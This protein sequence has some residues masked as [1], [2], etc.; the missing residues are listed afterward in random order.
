MIE[1]S[2]DDE[3]GVATDKQLVAGST[4]GER[5]RVLLVSYTF[6]PVGGAGVQRP[7][8][9]AK[10]LPQF[11]WDVTVLTAANPSVP[12]FDDSLCADV[13]KETVI[14]KAKTLEPS[15]RVKS[16]VAQ[17]GEHRSRRSIAG[18]AKR[19]ALSA[20]KL[21]LQPDP[22]ILWKRDAVRVA[23]RYLRNH[24]HD[25][26][27]ATAP[28]Y[29]AFL[30]G[31]ALSRKTG[32]PLLVDY[33]DE[34]DISNANWENRGFSRLTLGWQKRVQHRVL[35]QASAIVATTES[36]TNKL[37][38]LARRVGAAP[39]S[40]CIY[41]GYDPSDFAGEVLKDQK[42]KGRFRLVYTGTLWNLT[43]IEPLVLA[44]EALNQQQPESAARLELVF[45]GRRTESQSVT[46]H[47]LEGTRCK[48]TLLDYVEHSQAVELMRS[49]NALCLVLSGAAEASRVVPAKLFE[50]AAAGKPILTI[51][52][53]GEVWELLDKHPQRWLIEPTQPAQIAAVLAEAIH[54]HEFTESPSQCQSGWSP[55]GFSRVEQSRKLASL[56]NEVA[57]R[58]VKGGAQ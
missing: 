49:A 14:L 8:K 30:V 31:A 10:Y 34:W 33:R 6:P 13:P 43:C 40:R 50:Y 9:F 52:P 28:P 25:A 16:S 5:K 11:G 15:Y 37:A 45:A 29:S 42:S 53:K 46:L 24:P 22:Q 36:S 19:T 27:L 47:R 55:E 32:L 18:W 58:G 35:R 23:L 3:L 56:L 26:I 21:A 54:N 39:R 41:N 57:A 38:D 12:L 7:A 20:A 44:V 4:S 51:A 17:N 48:L 2:I 1:T